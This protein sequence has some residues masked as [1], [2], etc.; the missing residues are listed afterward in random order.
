MCENYQLTRKWRK[1]SATGLFI[2]L[3]N[4]DPLTGISRWVSRDEF[5]GKY[6]ALYFENGLSWG[7]RNSMLAKI[8]IIET[9]KSITPG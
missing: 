6:Q 3:A 7:R 2:E 4:P 9:D 8:Y 5:V 1:E